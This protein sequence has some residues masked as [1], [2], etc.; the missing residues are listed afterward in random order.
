M[1]CGEIFRLTASA[2]PRRV[3]PKHP[4]AN[5]WQ[6]NRLSRCLT[7]RHDISHDE[8]PE[9]MLGLV[10]RG[11]RNADAALDSDEIRA[12]V[13]AAASERVRVSFRPQSSEGLP[14]V[15]SDLK[16][17]PAKHAQALAIVSALKL[18]RTSTRS[19]ATSHRGMRALLDDEEYENFV[20]AAARLS[21]NPQSGFA[22]TVGLET[23]RYL[24]RPVKMLAVS[25]ASLL[26]HLTIM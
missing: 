8:L 14:G 7:F 6:P 5:W 10:A 12:L 18:P 11:D 25:E 16:L 24:R 26:R 19:A 15:I 23:C 1:T 9:R 4:A 20:A 21:R 2:G 3:S 17:P 13:I 22:A